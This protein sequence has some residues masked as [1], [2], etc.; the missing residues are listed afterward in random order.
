MKY[1]DIGFSGGPSGARNGA[2]LM[3]GGDTDSFHYLQPL[4]HDISL[5]GGYQHFQGSGAGHFVK[6]IHNG[7]EYGMMQSI[8][9]GMNIL[10]NSDYKIDLEKVAEIYNHGSVIESRLIGWLHDAFRIYGSDLK[11]I[12]GIVG[13]TGEGLWTVE[14]AKEFG[15]N[16]KVIEDSLQFRIDSAKNPEYTG[17]VVSALRNM[18]GG[19]NVKK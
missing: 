18:F 14:A 13:H 9:E 4:Y 5:P 12:S 10:K 3:I 7:I 11:D 8:A 6:M 16:A 19:H 15:L 17:Q 2:C 1:I